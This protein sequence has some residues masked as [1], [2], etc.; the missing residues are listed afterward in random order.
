MNLNEIASDNLI[1]P[2]AAD[3][4]STPENTT[5]S[6]G[7]PAATSTPS[8]MTRQ[9]SKVISEQQQE[10]E[11]FDLGDSTLMERVTPTLENMKDRKSVHPF[12]SPCKTPIIKKVQRQAT[13]SSLA[14]RVPRS[15]KNIRGRKRI[16]DSDTPKRVQNSK[17]LQKA[18]DTMNPRVKSLI[19]SSMNSTHKSTKSPRK[20]LTKTPRN[21]FKGKVTNEGNKIDTNELPLEQT[22]APEES[23]INSQIISQEKPSSKSIINSPEAGFSDKESHLES[24][25]ECDSEPPLKKARHQILQVN[26]GSPFSMTRIKKIKLVTL[27]ENDD[28]LV[29]SEMS[30][31]GNELPK[32]P[33]SPM[34]ES[35]LPKLPASPIER[36]CFTGDYC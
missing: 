21:E 23:P 10:L 17:D 35:L 34:K 22:K 7:Q 2:G 29:S 4:N 27:D 33:T 31:N 28:N 14:K 26:M 13:P 8:Y 16:R 19:K 9:R 36:I 12:K 24:S 18:P 1:V 5:I 11:A 3:N 30:G 32:L 25:V 20:P 15:F 6:S